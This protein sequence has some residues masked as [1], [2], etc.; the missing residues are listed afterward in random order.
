M[1]GCRQRTSLNI[2]NVITDY[3]PNC[4]I[5]VPPT[6]LTPKKKC[7]KLIEKGRKERKMFLV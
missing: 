7:L 2:S 5:P 1:N 3:V 4:L 6:V